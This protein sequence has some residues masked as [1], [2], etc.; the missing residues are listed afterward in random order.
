MHFPVVVTG[1]ITQYRPR[2]EHRFQTEDEGDAEAE[3][4]THRARAV[5]ASGGAA[6]FLSLVESVPPVL[7]RR[8]RPTDRRV[9]S[10]FRP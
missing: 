3:I 5:S 2:S 10:D 8:D 6:V 9:L 4:S 7:F 1:P